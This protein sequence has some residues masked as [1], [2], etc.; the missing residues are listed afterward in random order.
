[1]LRAFYCSVEKEFDDKVKELEEKHRK[2]LNEA[3]GGEAIAAATL[4][5]EDVCGVATQQGEQ[6]EP[7]NDEAERLRK[8]ERA[9][10]K[11]E[12]KKD[13]ERQRQEE[14]E[15]EAAEAGPSMRQ[16]ELEAL[17][18]KLKPLSMKIKEI[19]SDGNC[20]YRAVAVQCDSDYLKIREICANILIDNQDEYA[21]FCEYSDDIT[22]FE[23][24]VERVRSSSD[25]GGHLELRALAEGLKRPIIVYSATQPKLVL[26][27]EDADNPILLSYHLHYYSL[28]EHYNQ[29]MKASGGGDVTVAS[30]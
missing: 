22:S 2:E 20:L 4:P 30:E 23:Q 15:R 18:T 24:Y 3:G 1:V 21:P 26:G 7:D 16:I 29:V 8:Q 11:R 13:K 12:T 14:L 27:D 17:E 19:P 10:R 28:G 25:W 9:R 6:T 5:E